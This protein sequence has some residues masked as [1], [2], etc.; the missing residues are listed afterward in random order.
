MYRICTVEVMLLRDNTFV[1][2]SKSDSFD[3][4]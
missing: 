4:V 2:C 1:I 3:V